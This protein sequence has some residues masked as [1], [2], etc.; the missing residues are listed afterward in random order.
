MYPQELGSRGEVGG[1]VKR[2]PTPAAISHKMGSMSI[3]LQL[4][5]STDGYQAEDQVLC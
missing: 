2:E 1:A 3:F 4:N 5:T